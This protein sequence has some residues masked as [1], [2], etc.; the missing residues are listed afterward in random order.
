MTDN[1]DSSRG[2]E[3]DVRNA[4]EAALARQNKLIV[5]LS[6]DRGRCEGVVA[7]GVVLR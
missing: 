6:A 3:L 2:K 4:S 7:T 5:E 1:I